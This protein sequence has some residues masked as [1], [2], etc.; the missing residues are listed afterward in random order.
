M[1]AATIQATG[2]VRD[3]GARPAPESAA[4]LTWIRAEVCTR[5][6]GL[7][8]I[9]D[10][11]LEG[12]LPHT[13]RERVGRLRDGADSLSRTFDDLLDLC[14]IDAGHVVLDAQPF[15][16]REAVEVSLDQVAPMAA[17]RA[18]DLSCEIQGG[19]PATVL[20]D[21]GRLRQILVILLT[22]ACRRTDVGGVT[23]LVWANPLPRGHELH[24]AVRDSGPPVAA[25]R[26]LDVLKP[27]GE[28]VSSGDRVADAG[29]LG[30]AL[31]HALAHLMGGAVSLDAG[32][33]RGS[34]VRAGDRGR[35]AGPGSRGESC[36]TARPSC[37]GGWGFLATGTSSG[38]SRSRTRALRE[39][40]LLLLT[41]RDGLERGDVA[42]VERAAHALKRSASMIGAAPVVNGC[43]ELIT[44]LQADAL[45]DAAAPLARI[46]R[47]MAALPGTP[48]ASGRPEASS[49]FAAGSAE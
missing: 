29:D 24:F 21:V 7:V 25:S 28:I 46:E 3:A 40:S 32:E 45:A 43:T 12:N 10:L 27:L 16:L 20:G 33:G 31:C 48:S 14:R 44:V 15:N 35:N 1:T 5:I 34:D 30:L 38:R 18:L 17:E 9:A 36:P 37:H 42:A 41:M 8:G 6:N 22:N 2:A 11:L 47:A 4:V 13:E 19:T 39:G 23:I 26:V 49:A